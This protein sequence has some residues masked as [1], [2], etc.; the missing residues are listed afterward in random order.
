MPRPIRTALV[1]L[2]VLPPAAA[3]CGFSAKSE[4]QPNPDL[5]VPD[6][7]AGGRGSKGDMSNPDT[8]KK[9]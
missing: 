4:G 8:K 2:L 7:P 1:A 6:V 5:K 3:G 9:K